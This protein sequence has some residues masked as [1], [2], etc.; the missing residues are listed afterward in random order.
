MATTPIDNSL[1]NHP[2]Q[3]LI[4]PLKVGTQIIR[5][6]MIM[7]SMH[8]GLEDELWSLKKLADF[9]EERAKGGVGL[10][11]TGGFSPNWRGWLLPFASTM[12]SFWQIQKHK[13]VTQAVH[14]HGA[15]IALQ[16]LH[17]GRYAYHPFSVAPTGIKA[18]INPF[19][20]KAMSPSS[21]RQTIKDFASAA[22][23]AQKAG[24]DGVEI[25]G[26]EGYLINEFLSEK[27]NQRK[28]EWGGSL[29]NRMRFAVEI[30]KAV[31][32]A[33]GSDFLIIYRLSMLELVEKGNSIQD[34]IQ[35]AKAIEAA[36]ASIIGT[37]I[38]WH[39]ARIPTIATDVPRA[40]FA[41]V[42]AEIKKNISI[43]VIAS[44]RINTPEVAENILASEQADFISMARPWLAD[45][46][47]G[48]KALQQKSHLINTCIGCNQACL[49]H[50]FSR[51]QASCLVNPQAGYE[52]EFAINKTST[53]KKIA[54]V[55]AGPSGLS[56]AVTLAE[57]G[58]EVHLFDQAT[59]IGGQF[60]LAKQVPGKIEFAETIRYFTNRLQQLRVQVHLGKKITAPD[61]KK[62]NFVEVIVATGILPRIPPISGLSEALT[63][64]SVLSASS[65][66]RASSK[67]CQVVSYV[68]VLKKEVAIGKRIAVIGAGGI[69]F[70][71]S[72]FILHQMQH[73]GV[74]SFQQPLLNDFEKEWGIDRNLS[75]VGGL[76]KA[77]PF[78][79]G[80]G[81][82][83]KL[84]L[85]QRKAEALGRN[86]GKTTGWIHR[87]VLK[88]A[89]VEMLSGVDY[90][91]VTAQGLVIT[92]KG[93]ERLLDVDQII[94]CAGQESLNELHK[95][96]LEAG[97]S[98]E[99]VH[100]IGGAKVAL[101]LDAKAAIR[102]GLLIGLKC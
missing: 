52:K 40:A 11:I 65:S 48:S 6:R 100:L 50:I 60:N 80:K 21:I 51:K 76:R 64:S 32:A 27:T 102:D 33:V 74:D 90:K 83:F 15:K 89:G 92:H 36:G 77:E 53:R 8:T 79:L 41:W 13:T 34:N 19:K 75:T 1:Q 101:E 78:E 30:I 99:Q 39:E 14:K 88:N 38:G 49:D 68:Q 91:Q 82:D 85:M 55:G 97:Y 98:N 2:Y 70:D 59:S 20:P 31:R 37:G 93:Q 44:N 28:D 29:Q 22:K 26:S 86:L 62:E 4:S 18:P 57:R 24:Y 43:P 72:K 56:A 96:C 10:I 3:K 5:N 81:N 58:H 66:S 12:H 35:I 25:M 17:A 42:T 16:L 61:L 23:L 95:A 73:P 47:F 94:V 67:S 71:I 9:Y 7:G 84:Y 87:A 63:S 46:E 45:A 54:V 69:G